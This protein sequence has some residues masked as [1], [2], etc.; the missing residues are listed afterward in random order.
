MIIRSYIPI[1]SQDYE[2]QLVGDKMSD[3]DIL[4]IDIET[5]F[6]YEETKKLE[7]KDNFISIAICNKEE[8][9][10]AFKNFGIDAWVKESAVSLGALNKIIEQLENSVLE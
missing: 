2:I 5:I 3:S 7:A 4:I 1:S 6:E 9:M 8:D 10:S